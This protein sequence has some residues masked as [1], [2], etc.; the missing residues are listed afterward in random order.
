MERLYCETA[1]PQPQTKV[2]EP[3]ERVELAVGLITEAGVGAI[4]LFTVRD[5]L[6]VRA[7][8]PLLPVTAKLDVPLGVVGDNDTVRT[9]T[10]DPAMLDGLKLQVPPAGKPVTPFRLLK[11]TDPVKPL[12][13]FTLTP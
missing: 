2:A 10:P 12:T 13:G 3:P 5:A 6:A 11:L 4:V 8:E 1:T 9:L 7:S